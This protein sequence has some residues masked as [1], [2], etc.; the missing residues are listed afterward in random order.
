MSVCPLPNS[1]NEL[2]EYAKQIGLG[3]RASTE[4]LRAFMQ[5]NRN[6]PMGAEPIVPTN[7]EF[8]ALMD[9]MDVWNTEGRQVIMPDLYAGFGDNM[10]AFPEYSVLVNP[11]KL[12]AQSQAN[13]KAAATVTVLAQKLSSNLGVP[14]QFITP[15][16]A[17]E[18]TKNVNT[19]K[20]QSA[21]FFGGVVYMIPEL[22]TEKSVLHEFAH[23]LIRAIRISNPTLFTKLTNE[24]K[25]SP[26]GTRL[27]AEAREEYSDLTADD[28][29][30]LEEALV[31]S[32][33]AQAVD[34]TDSAFNKFIKNF[35][36]MFNIR[37][38]VQL[39]LLVIDLCYSWFH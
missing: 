30:I 26:N 39:L 31:K 2:T 19:W 16:E 14:Y 20:G 23:P 38:N 18:L 15:A 34:K 12:D 25:N 5:K 10:N 3:P 11:I 7:E 4:V 29:I 32:L 35:L 17:A 22:V 21:F 28:P 13:L 9:N 36:L 6:L 37:M 33:T 8:K 1:L 24:L 27:L